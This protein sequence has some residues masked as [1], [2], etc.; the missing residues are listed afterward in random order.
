MK[1]QQRGCLT[2]PFHMGFCSITKCFRSL[3]NE[4]HGKSQ[5]HLGIRNNSKKI[6]GTNI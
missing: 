6:S 2:N 3:E 1:T 4:I 5:N